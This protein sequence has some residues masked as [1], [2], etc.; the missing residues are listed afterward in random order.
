MLVIRQ[1][2]AE[3]F[4]PIFAGLARAFPRAEL[5]CLLSPGEASAVP[6]EARI[7]FQPGR[8]RPAALVRRLRAQRFRRAAWAAEP[9]DRR[10]RALAAE[11]LIAALGIREKLICHPG[12]GWQRVGRWRALA[13]PFW[14]ALEAAFLCSVCAAAAA[15]SFVLLVGG[16][17]VNDLAGWAA[18]ERFRAH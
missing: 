14:H 2:P 1:L 8:D 9:G 18:G 17:L 7:I 13:Q 5:Y 15:T 16:A 10:P 6:A 11:L 4:G 12:R 3:D